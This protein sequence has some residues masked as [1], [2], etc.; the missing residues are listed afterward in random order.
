M[1]RGLFLRKVQSQLGW[2]G[3]NTPH[4]LFIDIRTDLKVNVWKSKRQIIW[5]G[6]KPVVKYFEY[7]SNKKFI[8]KSVHFQKK[9]LLKPLENMKTNNLN[10]PIYENMIKLWGKPVSAHHQLLPGVNIEHFLRI[11]PQ[12]SDQG[13]QWYLRYP[14]H[15]FEVP[16]SDWYNQYDF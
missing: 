16:I 3:L 4:C 2:S 11:N 1:R 15:P 6:A 10:V 14:S 7:I 9:N 8:F 13:L 12:T 5:N